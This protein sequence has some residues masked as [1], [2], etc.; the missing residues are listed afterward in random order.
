[1]NVRNVG[2]P[3]HVL[4]TF[5]DTR[6]SILV[7][8]LTNVRSVERLFVMIHSLDFISSFIPVSDALNVR[9]VGRYIVVPHN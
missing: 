7:K 2:R 8:N 1:M 3:S 6:Q 5:L 4:L 9:N